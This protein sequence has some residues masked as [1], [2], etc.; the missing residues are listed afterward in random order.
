MENNFITGFV[1]G[2]ADYLSENDIP[3]TSEE[4]SRFFVVSEGQNIDISNE[5]QMIELLRSVFCHSRRAYDIL[6]ELF[7]QYISYRRITEFS[8]NTDNEI[9]ELNS[10]HQAILKS[11]QE[12]EKTRAE[13]LKELN[14]RRSAA[15]SEI[16]KKL[17]E[18]KLANKPI[19][20]QLDNL[21]KKILMPKKKV[22]LKKLKR[23]FRKRI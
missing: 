18:E 9:N 13:R 5:E 20:D 14:E 4:I 21:D 2:F 15:E 23:L 6:P 7:R 8:K 16:R 17:L 19:A 10:Q 3:V 11:L 1:T 12:T 22:L